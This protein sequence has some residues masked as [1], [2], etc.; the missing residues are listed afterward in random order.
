MIPQKNPH[1]LITLKNA[2]FNLKAIQSNL[3]KHHLNAK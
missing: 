1:E 3:F 2:C